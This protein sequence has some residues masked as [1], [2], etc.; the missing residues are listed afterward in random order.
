VRSRRQFLKLIP[1]AAGCAGF[2]SAAEASGDLR[3][4]YREPA[5]RWIEAL[6]I[7]NGRLGAMVFGGKD[8][9]HL[10][11]NEDTL[12]SGAPR[13]WNNPDAKR[14]L[15]EVRRLVLE[16]RNYAEAT[17]LCKK[18]QGP[19]NES[20]LPLG[21]LYLDFDHGGEASNYI[22][23]LNLD[24]AIVRIT[25]DAEGAHFT[26]EMFASAPDQVIVVHLSC[27]QP[28]R[29]T[30][31]ATMDSLLRHT[32]GPDADN[33]LVVRGKAPAHVDH[34]STGDSQ[35]H[36]VYDDVEGRGMRF[37]TRVL[38]KASGGTV[39][40][41]GTGIRVENADSVTILISAATGFRGFARIPDRPSEAISA[42]CRKTLTAAGKESY[43]RLRREHVEDYRNL[44]RRVRLRL[45]RTSAAGLPP[46]E[47]IRNFGAQADPQLVE[48]Y[49]QYGRY[50]LICSSRPGSQPANL[51]GIWNDMVHPPWSSNWTVNINTE[52]NYWHAETANLSE[53]HGPLF[54]MV[55]NLSQTGDK[56]ARINYGASGWTCHHNVDLWR[57]SAPVGE[58]AGAPR[59][60]NWPMGGA[61]L[62][63]HL[64]EH[65]AFG[66]DEKFL[67]ERAY[68]LMK[69][70]AE[71]CLDWLIPDSQGR[72][73]TCP[74]VS[75]ENTFRTPEGNL[76]SVSAGCSMDLEIIRDLFT[77]CI[78]AAS[79]LR[80][81]DEFR[82]KLQDAC[83]RM[84]PLQVGKRGQLQE[85]WEDFDE[86]EP[87]HRHMSHLFGLHPGRQ[88]TLRGTPELARAARVS[89]ERRLANGGGHTGWSRAWLINFWARLEEGGIAHENV[90]ALLKNSTS[91]NLFDL[92]PPFQID[93]N[94]GGAAGI[95]E[96]LL[97]S[98]AGEI[99]FLPALPT[100]WP[101]G[102]FRGLRAR[103]GLEID[104][105]WRRGQAHR[106]AL[107]ASVDGEHRLRAPR[108]QAAVPEIVRIKRGQSQT[109]RFLKSS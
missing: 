24:D 96:M 51:Q 15:S 108:G 7:G 77:N 10:Q 94:F 100:S 37:E 60:A 27:N 67:Q 99:H 85:W 93:G 76:A 11:L 92:H 14:H 83:A 23:E 17:D 65:Y 106:A 9:E 70:A 48:L 5:S 72:L 16:E 107:R 82:G 81:D 43:S 89:L 68:P 69:G 44:F 86:P 19:Y 64:W 74:S 54:D 59:W 41:G 49:F 103:G 26:R 104:L 29:L 25:Y 66:R 73:V 39:A 36:V 35:Q 78:E 95:I 91:T 50:L 34:N 22:R 90:M 75:P 4:W 1:A 79:I 80:I 56:T 71:F 88:I 30:F 102:E 45:G 61:W 105:E 52:M 2:A 8:R 53:C 84:L 42:A 12:W 20:Y 28:R 32:V 33:S 18:M 62:S 38:V 46:A 13:E 3:L 21:N 31:T 63:R 58:G 87:G 6:P 55:S 109:I 98:H 97:Q 101:D 40:P 47:R 57:Q